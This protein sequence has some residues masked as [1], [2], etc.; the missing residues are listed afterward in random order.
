MMLENKSPDLSPLLMLAIT[1]ISSTAEAN[2]GDIFEDAAAFT[3][4][5]DRHNRLYSHLLS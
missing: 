2:K 4:H 1:C 3:I 5:F